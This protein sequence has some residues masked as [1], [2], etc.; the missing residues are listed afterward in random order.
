MLEHHGPFGV[1]ALLVFIFGKQ[2][3][4]GMHLIDVCACRHETR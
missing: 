1:L 3:I 2:C 4:E